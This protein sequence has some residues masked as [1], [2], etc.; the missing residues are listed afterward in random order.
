MNARTLIALLLAAAAAGCVDNNG[1]VRISSACFPPTPNDDGSC[2]YPAACESVMMGNLWVDTTYVPTGGTLYW[3]FQADNQRPDN[4]AR[5]GG[6]N[7]A[8]AFIT[9]F[10]ISYT[11]A[12]VSLPDANLD[13]TTR[14]VE[15]QGSTVLSI[16]VIPAGIAAL[17]SANPGLLA[18]V[19]AEIR[20]K[21]HYG[22]G[23][24]FETGPFSVVVNVENGG[25]LG[26]SCPDPAAPNPIGMC[27]QPGQTGVVLCK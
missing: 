8:T 15:A 11:S 19:R 10:K 26:V 4:G 12:V 3:P 13:D 21:G 17:L 25:W 2:S 5:D 6:T 22:D 16:P 20:A 9:G 18:Q 7:T 24:D 27:P 1:S 14:T 23:Q